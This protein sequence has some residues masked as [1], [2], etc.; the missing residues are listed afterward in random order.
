MGKILVIAEKPSAGKDIAR[1]LGVTKSYNGYMEN[2]EYIVSW[3]VGHLVTLKDPEDQN[4]RYSKWSAEDLPLPPADGL[5][6]IESAKQQFQIIKKLIQRNDIKYLIN[7]GD[8]G[9]EG[10]LIQTWIYRMAGNRHPVKILWA[11]SLT[12]E[13]IRFSMNH[14]HDSDEEEFENLLR[15]AETRAEADKIY[16]YN[17]TR[18]LTCLYG[19]P[20][21]VLSY[22][23]C[24]TPLLHLICKRDQENAEFVPEPYWTVTATFAE[25]FTATEADT[26]G[27]AIRYMNRKEA[28]DS[29]QLRDR[30]GTIT[31]CRSEIKSIKAPA[32]FNLAEI[33]NTM[34]KKYGLKPDET[35]AVAQRL[36]ET[37]KIMSYPRT[38]S[39][40]LSTDL[41]GEIAEHVKSCNFGK[42]R[43]YIERID[44][45]SLRMDKAYFN[46]NKV[47]DHHALIPTINWNTE[48][49]Y[50][51]LSE[52]EKN[53]FDE[54][55]A[56]LIAIFFAEY[57][58]ESTIIKANVSGREFYCSGSM[59]ITSGFKEV[60]QL[61][62]TQEKIADGEQNLPKL[63]TGQAVSISNLE[64][65]EGRTKPPAKYHPGNIVKLM[66]KYKIGTSATSANIIKTLEKRGFIVLDGKK[67]YTSTDLG[68]QFLEI[69]PDELQSEYLTI[70][71]EE[72]LQKVNSG[73]LSKEDFLADIY[74]QIQKNIKNIREK[75]P[76]K[77]LGGAEDIGNCPK[78]GKPIMEGKKNWYCPG[79]SSPTPCNFTIWKE[80]AGKKIPPEEVKKLLTNG[81][82]KLIKGFHS[83]KGN[84]FDAYLILKEDKTIGFSFPEKKKTR[85][86]LK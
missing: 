27:K 79:Y 62:K 3:A 72:K 58:Y 75:A 67:K 66:G 16:G 51:T 20:G 31:D 15:E 63:K 73:E 21:A 46:D 57:Q 26:E 30:L 33:Q 5:K 14:L 11:S 47:S 74:Q 24:Q 42:F 80:I 35:L 9:R 55:A 81:R 28:E 70:Q 22:G 8:A 83:S 10:L 68:R 44:F 34:G 85:K 40:Y 2:E 84:S 41:Y 1:I 43:K 78:C 56:S 29:C 13:A 77:K 6:V 86:N 23:R 4:R 12:D 25:G 52:N 7:A 39:R 49:I 61:L 32:L 48:K 64:I 36:Y 82:T 71:F 76:G 18:L 19:S 53:F 37:H 59:L 60:F 17:Y 50:E 38:D 69:V 54:I 45:S 65:K